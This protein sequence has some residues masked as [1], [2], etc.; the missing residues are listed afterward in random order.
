MLKIQKPKAAF[1]AFEF[2]FRLRPYE[3]KLSTAVSGNETGRLL[4]TCFCAYL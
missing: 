1:A 4:P 3:S 2:H